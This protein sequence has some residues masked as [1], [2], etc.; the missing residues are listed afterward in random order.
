MDA[1][2]FIRGLT[3]KI[4]RDLFINNY[5]TYEVLAGIYYFSCVTRKTVER[6][7]LSFFAAA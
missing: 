2:L 7:L 5:L 6:A 1:T 3:I 4:M